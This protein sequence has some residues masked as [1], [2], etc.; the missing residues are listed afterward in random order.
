MLV[1]S[2]FY[3]VGGDGNDIGLMKKVANVLLNLFILKAEPST[4]EEGDVRVIHQVVNLINK[5]GVL[6]CGHWFQ[7]LVDDL[8][9]IVRNPPLYCH[10]CHPLIILV[11]KNRRLRVVSLYL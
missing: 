3:V 7:E 8:Y 6:V 2:F 5:P 9:M 4:V 1:I 11:V 10:G